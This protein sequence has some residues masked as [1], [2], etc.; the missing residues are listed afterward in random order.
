MHAT[1][2]G[3]VLLSTLS[4]E[5]ILEVLG[6][7]PEK[8]TDSTH[9]IQSLLSEMVSI[10]ENG[11]ATDH[12]EHTVGIS[13]CSILIPTFMGPHAVAVVAPTSRFQM[14]AEEFR[15]ALEACRASISRLAGEY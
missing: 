10:R 3:K 5:Q 13:A 11:F 2:D 7:S 9:G 6:Q 14:R 4:D 8:L 12:Q 15:Q 1:A